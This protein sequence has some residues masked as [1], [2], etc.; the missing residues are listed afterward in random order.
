MAWS[1]KMV[2]YGDI[3]VTGLVAL[4]VLNQGGPDIMVTGLLNGCTFCMQNTDNGVAMTHIRP[5]GGT[6]AVKLQT[7]VATRG[8]FAGSGMSMQTFGMATEYSGREDATI[9]GIRKAG[10]WRVYAQIHERM[11]Q[12][13]S[14]VVKIFGN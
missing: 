8:R 1:V 12:E 5:V 4:N 2:N 3:D 11:A 9:I 6:D 10:S 7:E 13:I 14:R